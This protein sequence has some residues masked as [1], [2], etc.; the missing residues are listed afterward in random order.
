VFGH[1]G[2][3][4]PHLNKSDHIEKAVLMIHGSNE[5]GELANL[6]GEKY[7]TAYIPHV[8]WLRHEPGEEVINLLRQGYFEASEQAFYWLYLRPGDTFIDG[9]AHIG[10]YSIIADRVTNGE[11]R[12]IA[13][14]C[15]CATADCL[16]YNLRQNGVKNYQI[17]RSAI[18]SSA[19]T[20]PF[21]EE[22]QGK[23]AYAHVG[24]DG[25]EETSQLVSTIT[26]DQIITNIKAEEVSLVKLDIEGAEPEAIKGAQDAIKHGMFQVLM[27]EFTEKNLQRRGV[28]SQNLVVQ[29]EKLGYVLCEFSPEQLQVVPFSWEGP[30]WFKNL[31]ACRAPEK[32]NARLRL[33][34]EGNKIIARDILDRA[35]ACSRFKELEDLEQYR[36]LGN[37]VDE[38]RLWAERAESQL[39][40]VK[41]EAVSNRTWAER[42]ESQLA[43]VKQ[44]VVDN[45]TWA[46][47]TEQSLVAERDISSRAN[48]ELISLRAFAKR[49]KWLY[50]IFEFL[51][52]KSR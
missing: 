25:Q 38:Y 14:E 18:W 29:L 35:S 1:S 36:K 2:Y 47:R 23:A 13:V 50:K 27:V 8:G 43:Q 5:A 45:R 4:Q 41:Q 10:L 42:A 49:F 30:I 3:S 11:T 21:I 34:T 33:A 51:K 7:D 37:K 44:E 17:F 16:E 52:Q 31:F 19:G 22:R 48:S 6:A 24:F 32:V 26:L 9:G 12:V 40:Q 39:A 46:E 28:S 15:R 20:I